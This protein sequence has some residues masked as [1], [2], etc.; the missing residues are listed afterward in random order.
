MGLSLQ[1]VLQRAKKDGLL[2][3][4]DLRLELHSAF[5]AAMIPEGTA[6]VKEAATPIAYHGLLSILHPWSGQL[7]ALSLHEVARKLGREL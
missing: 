6:G 4:L 1:A 7:E 5:L 3:G 2:G